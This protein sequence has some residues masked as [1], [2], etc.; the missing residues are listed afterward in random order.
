MGRADP[1]GCRSGTTAAVP[2]G[3]QRELWQAIEGIPHRVGTGA[4]WCDLPERSG[5]WKTVH[6]RRRPWSAEGTWKRLLQQVQAGGRRRQGLGPLAG[7]IRRP[8][9]P[10]RGWPPQQQPLPSGSA[11]D[12]LDK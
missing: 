12:H 9:P 4:R 7:R 6:E 2:A 5:P 10:G 8:G 3:R 11:H 1:D